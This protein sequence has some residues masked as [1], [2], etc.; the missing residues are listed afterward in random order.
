MDLHPRRND[1]PRN[2]NSRAVHRR[3]RDDARVVRWRPRD[4]AVCW[5]PRDDGGWCIG[6][7][8]L[9]RGGRCEIAAKHAG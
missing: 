9:M 2:A 5:R 6:G 1:A 3:P 4:G 7:R 8:W